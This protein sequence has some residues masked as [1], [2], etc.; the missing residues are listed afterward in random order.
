V[1][2]YCEESAAYLFADEPEN[3]LEGRII[4]LLRRRRG[5]FPRSAV[6]RAFKG[7]VRSYRLDSAIAAL[8]EQELIEKRTVATPGRP[9]TEYRLKR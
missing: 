6:Q 8:E 4:R 2:R 7:N 3:G 1:W 9:R 5:W